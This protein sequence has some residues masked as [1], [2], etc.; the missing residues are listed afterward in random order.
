VHDA[1]NA[2]IAL[3]AAQRRIKFDDVMSGEEIGD[4]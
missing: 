4:A 3:N 2:G 1:I